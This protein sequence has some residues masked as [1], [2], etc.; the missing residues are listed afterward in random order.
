MNG[1]IDNDIN[2]GQPGNSGDSEAKQHLHGSAKP[3]RTEHA[4]PETGSALKRFVF[5]IFVAG[6]IVVALLWTRSREHIRLVA[7]TNEM[8]ISTVTVTYPKASPKIKEITLPGNLT[9]FSEVSIFARTN[10]YLKKWYADLGAKVSEG[11]VLAELEAPDLDAQLLQVA[12]NQAQAKANLENAKLNFER[13]KSL[14]QNKATSQQEFDRAKTSLEAMEA[15]LRADEANV[16]NLTVQKGFQKI[17]AP[18][19]AVVTRRNTDVGALV[20]AGT[21]EE[22]FHLARTDI[23]RVFIS[24]PQVYSSAVKVDT[25]AYLELLEFPGEKFPGKI[26][27]I[28]GAIDPKTR[29][30]LT[31]MQVSNTEGRLFPGAYARVH[32][33]LALEKPAITVPANTLVFRA[34][35]IQVA[36]VDGDAKIHL[37][38]VTIGHDFGSEV[39]I[40]EGLSATDAIVLNPSDSIAAGSTVRVE[41]HKE[42]PP[43]IAAKP[44]ER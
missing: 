28:S 1:T 11:E 6:V 18:F 24:L 26:V 40:T 25:E 13:Q 41:E 31:E 30:L 14:L 34:E 35:G 21:G 39:E 37:K 9:A 3:S 22:L 12:A 5:G 10:G 4:Q 33:I 8:A 7:E 29:T 23:L 16:Q 2:S 42:A 36:S 43:A 17:A 15:G 44:Q 32:L 38:K 27:N 20:S 19:P